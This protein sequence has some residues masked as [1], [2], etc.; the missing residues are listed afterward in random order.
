MEMF[1]NYPA[2]DDLSL[3]E[4][5]RQD[6]YTQASA[7]KQN[8]IKLE[9][10]QFTYDYENHICFFDKY[11]PNI[12]SNEF[13]NKTILDLGSFTGGRLVYWMERYN[14]MEGRGIDI[15]P[16]F[17]EAGN[18]FSKKKNVNAIFD[19]GFGEN[20][21]YASNKFDFIISFDVFE[22]VRNIETVMQECFRVLKPGGT[23]LAVFP[24]F[25]Q[26]LESHLGLVTKMPAIHWLFSGKTIANAYF[27]IIKKRGKEAYWYDRED[28]DLKEWERLPSLNGI[29]VSKFRRII[30][31]NYGWKILH[32]GKEPI[33]N[34]G[35]R[36]NMLVF[37]IIKKLFIL[38][39][40][41]PILEELFLGKICCSLEKI[42]V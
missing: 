5:F 15:N 34:D 24:P 9:S 29:T 17:A 18:Q 25:Y 31:A 6:E 14:F 40:R 42:N 3:W 39:A 28:P 35:R 41:L 2:K 12:S 7:E 33:L 4:I 16:I 36:A 37:R 13:R 10:A 22:H 30:A 1:P 19:T 21:P 27:E 11:F 23:L 32:W 38:P 8:R 20:L 26:P